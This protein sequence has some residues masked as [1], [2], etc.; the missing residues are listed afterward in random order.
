MI[1]TIQSIEGNSGIGVPCFSHNGKA[2]NYQYR[3]FSPLK[4]GAVKV[5]ENDSSLS[6]P[7]NKNIVSHF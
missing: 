5:E 6:K 3:V 1:I 4:E 2:S 7:K